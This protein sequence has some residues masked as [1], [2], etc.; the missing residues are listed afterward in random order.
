MK[1]KLKSLLII[2]S[3]FSLQMTAQ[4]KK[5]LSLMKRSTWVFK[6]ANIKN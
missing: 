5:T 4:E 6:T 1:N 3:L 2:F